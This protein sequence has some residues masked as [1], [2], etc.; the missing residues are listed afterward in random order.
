MGLMSRAI[1]G[2]VLAAALAA[3]G[4]ST[5]F[6]ASGEPV[7]WGNGQFGQLGAGQAP[8]S[9]EGTSSDRPIHVSAIGAVSQLAVGEEHT[10]AL[11]PGG[12]LEGWGANNVGQL[13][14]EASSELSY[15]PVAVPGVE[16]ASAIAAAGFDSYALLGGGTV[17]AWGSNVEGQLGRGTIGTFSPTPKPVE[18]LNEVVAI[19]AGARFALALRANGTVEA[20]GA[21]GSGQLGDGTTETRDLPVAVSGLSEV[22][23]IAAGA[24]FG[25]ALLADGEVRAWGSDQF[26]QLGDEQSCTCRRS[27]V[28]VPVLGLSGASAIAA[29]KAHALAL[30]GGGT[31]EAWGENKFGQLGDGTTSER[32]VPV[33]VAGL[34]GASAVSAGGFHSVALREDGTVEDWGGNEHGQLGTGS[35]GAGEHSAVPVALGCALHGVSGI[36]SGLNVSLAFGVANELCPVIASVTPKEGE[37]GTVVTIAGSGFAEASAVTFGGA[38]ATSFTVESPTRISATAPAG[39]ETVDIQVRTPVGASQPSRSDRYSYPGQPV[40]SSLSVS[41]GVEPGFNTIMIRGKNLASATAVYFGTEPARSFTPGLSELSAVVPAGSGTV[42]VRVVNPNGESEAT[43]ADRYAYFSPPEFGRCTATK[44]GQ[45]EF[46]K[47]SC[48][49]GASEFGP[50]KYEWWAAFSRM[51]LEKT[52]FTLAGS[53]LTLET[54]GGTSIACASI[55]GSGEYESAAALATGPLTLSGCKE[56][57]GALQGAACQSPSAASGVVITSALEGTLGRYLQGSTAKVGLSL[58]PASGETFAQL[59]CGASTIV[60]EGGPIVEVPHGKMSAS[61]RWKALEKK[62]LQ[63]PASFTGEPETTLHASIS[64]GASQAAG[65]K[66]KVT[67]TSEEAVE[68]NNAY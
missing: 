8:G 53:S 37:P 29:G 28:P 47:S 11:L 20:W 65:L 55:E 56:A 48:E 34:S 10:L 4:A 49:V 62:G 1:G 44:A 9:N 41:K 21:N 14:R 18:G 33:A 17:E 3:A 27:T 67:Q 25:L 15:V 64:G 26:G 6:G 35:E 54:A 57:K 61:A 7:A 63:Q 36:A 23:A 52:G 22:V 60:L 46:L 16:G 2:F 24:E 50:G 13:G 43:S 68:V 38:P 12:T 31:V 58:E 39:T 59:S 30:L 51:E 40:V 42:D 19:A 66:A 32:N 5:A 45:G